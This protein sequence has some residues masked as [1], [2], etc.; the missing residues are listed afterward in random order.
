MPSVSTSA[1]PYSKLSAVRSIS[2][3]EVFKSAGKLTLSSGVISLGCIIL[4]I[5][6]LNKEVKE[7]FLK[8]WDNTI[9]KKGQDIL[10]KF[11]KFN[12]IK[13]DPSNHEMPVIE[14]MKESDSLLKTL[15]YD[16]ET[17]S[18]EDIKIF[19]NEVYNTKIIR[20][21]THDEV[22]GDNN[23]ETKDK[24]FEETVMKIV[25]HSAEAFGHVEKACNRTDKLLENTPVD[26]IN[27]VL[28]GS[29]FLRDLEKKRKNR[30]FEN[31]VCA[32]AFSYVSGFSSVLFDND[33]AVQE[34][35]ERSVEQL[36]KANF[37]GHISE[38]SDEDLK[39]LFKI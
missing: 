11:D 16:V 8:K 35:I 28:S 36:F 4:K 38:L 22:T 34:I 37:T 5:S 13:F 21:K 1:F 24:K 27:K 33:D 15:P 17:L 14:L 30:K 20:G 31:L 3:K 2:P 18:F 19:F 32:I 6:D 25:G 10:D 7:S 9:S 29:I 23:E 26:K 12:D 39:S